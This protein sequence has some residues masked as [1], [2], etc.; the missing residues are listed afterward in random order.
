MK[1]FVP[2][3]LKEEF[4]TDQVDTIDKRKELFDNLWSNGQHV[5]INSDK[6]EEFRTYLYN[7]N[8]VALKDYVNRRR[9][10]SFNDN[11]AYSFVKLKYGE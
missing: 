1:S 2:S 5:I 11:T 4:S 7:N 6:Y 9:E 8:Y 10:Y 3:F